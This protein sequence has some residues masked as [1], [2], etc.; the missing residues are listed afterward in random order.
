MRKK[1][2][3]LVGTR[4]EA[5]KMAPVVRLLRD[6]PGFDCRLCATGQHREMLAG[7]LADFGLSPNRDLAVMTEGQT[8]ASLSS[9]LLT[10]LDNLYQEEA[11]ALVLA[12]GDTTTV[13]AGAL[14]AFYR[15]IPFGHVEA[16]LRSFDRRAP[17]PEEVNRRM[18]GVIADF[19]FAPTEKARQNLLA[20]GVDDE[21]IFVVGNTVIDALI[22]TV[23][24]L[25]GKT[26]MLPQAVG[27]ALGRGRRLILVTA[28]R[29]ETYEAGLESL[30]RG[31]L[32]LSER[33]P[34]VLLVYPVH[35]NP[36][37][38]GPVQALLGG[39]ENILLL[40]PLPYRP[41]VALMK[42]AYLALTDSGGVQEEAPALGKPVLV[43]REKTERPEGVEAGQAL[44]VGTESGAIV[45]HVEKLLDDDNLYARMSAANS[46]YGDGRSARRI[47][48]ILERKL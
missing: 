12:Q 37:V 35:P 34:D 42:A 48:D 47:V 20:E 15:H 28:H 10:N 1:I 33:R 45:H 16:G 27:E 22:W 39:R 26:D 38:R 36:R 24:S 13:M 5:I 31:L 3:V 41:F 29:R 46:P 11:P 44:L 32:S 2:L 43:L 4:P 23:D 30:C 9:T 17:F 18:A 6:C 25:A 14:A 7:A 19:H 21:N 40:E 8:L